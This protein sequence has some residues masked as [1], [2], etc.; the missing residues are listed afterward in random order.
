MTRLVRLLGYAADLVK[1]GQLNAAVRDYPQLMT[2]LSSPYFGGILEHD[3]KLRRQYVVGHLLRSFRI[4]S[5]LTAALHHY[6]AMRDLMSPE[7]FGD[8]LGGGARIWSRTVEE[9]EYRVLLKYNRHFFYE[10]DIALVFSRGEK[11]LFQI[12]FSIVPGA[13]LDMAER[14][15][16]LIA[17]AQGASLESDEMKRAVK[18]NGGV[19]PSHVAMAALRGV[20]SALGLRAIVAAGNADQ[21]AKTMPEAP[22]FSFDY[23]AFWTMFGGMPNADGLFS[24]PVEPQEKPLLEIPIAHRRRSRKKREFKAE[25]TA[26]AA[27]GL[28]RHLR[29]RMP[30]PAPVLATAAVAA[31]P[32]RERRS[33]VK[34][35]AAASAPLLL[36]SGDVGQVLL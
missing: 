8:M 13:L 7:C 5:R 30:A 6:R 19:A 22:S 17:G 33:L 21:I 35:V 20:A 3:P 14:D 29:V 16:M 34:H 23:D 11:P 24:V 12:S 26:G 18:A 2:L 32:A 25:V 28:N 15:V 1:P 9:D 31:D 27:R 36:I 10:G 4:R